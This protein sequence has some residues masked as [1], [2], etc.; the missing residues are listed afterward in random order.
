MG[1][2]NLEVQM[3][4]TEFSVEFLVLDINT[5]YNLLLR[6]PWI[7]MARAVQSTLHQ[8][9]KFVWKDQDL[10]IHGEWSFSNRYAPI[11][12]EVSRGCDF[13]TV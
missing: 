2:V 12:N 3:G 13:Y 6:R 4:H 8:S 11:V 10:V 1:A 5:I 9:M 7:H